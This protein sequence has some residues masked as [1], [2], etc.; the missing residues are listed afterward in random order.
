MKLLLVTLPLFIVTSAVLKSS[1]A[2]KIMVIP[3]IMFESHLQ[4]FKTLAKALHEQGHEVVIVASQGREIVESPHYRFQRYVGM[5][6]SQTADDFLQEKMK[7]IF[8]GKL[9]ALQL[10]GILD[11]YTANCDQMVGNRD[12]EDRLREEKFDLLLVD[13][14]EMC[15]Y[16]FAE[17]LGVKHVTFST[18]LWFPAELGAP[19]PVSY[20]PEFNSLMTD[21]M[22]FW[23]RA[24]N[25][26]TY[27][28][29]RIGTRCAILPKYDAI[30]AKH[31]VK[32]YRSMLEVVQGS[33]M[34][35]LCTDVALE[36]PRPSLPSIA[37]VGGIL[38]RHANPLPEDLATWVEDAPEGVVVVSFGA[39]VKYLSDSLTEKLAA[40]FAQLPHRV[41]WRFFGKKPRSLGNNTKLMEWIPQND[42]LGHRNVK[43]FLSHGGLNGIY[44]SI[45][46]GVP[47]VG[48]PFFGDHYDIMTRIHAKGMGIFLTWST[49]T[50]EDIYRAIVAVATDPRYK[51]QAMYLSRLHQ[52][53]P[54]HPVNRAVYWLEYVLRHDGAAH[55]RPTLYDMVFYQYYMLDVVAVFIVCIILLCYCF[56]KM[57][58]KL[59]GCVLPKANNSHTQNG[60]PN[61][62]VVP[63]R[64]KWE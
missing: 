54:L 25:S 23:E 13:P 37:F 34:F 8:S 41:L 35:L 10:F 6:T 61:R 17:I 21:R 63:E 12:L 43:A 47:V 7:N 57:V 56:L 4:I 30:L 45:Y 20:V 36:F 22:N 46:H 59:K 27:I 40:A 55:L 29:S 50:E 3:P 1:M 5:F 15:G 2:A 39:G 19:S 9:T 32:P 52:D 53:Q 26:L 58:R 31:S 11:S 49:M 38:T 51:K 60:I 64:K 42:L 14:N 62:K 24:W 16:V 33:S 48:V 18:G 28:V 44:E